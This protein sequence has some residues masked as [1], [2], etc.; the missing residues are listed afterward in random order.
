MRL[1]GKTVLVTGGARRIG[2]ALSLALAARGCHVVIHSRRPLAAARRLAAQVRRQRVRAWTVSGDFRDAGA[3]ARVFREAWTAAGRI[4]ILINNAAVFRKQPL[5][6]A[7]EDELREHWDVNLLAPLLL[8]RAFARRARHGLVLNL[9][10]TRVASARADAVPYALSK[11]SL[12]DLTRLAA[13]ELAPGFRVNGLAPGPV[14]APRA[15][16]STCEPAGPIPLRRRP[17]VRDVAAAAIFLLE[18]D[19][20]TGQVLFVDGGQHLLG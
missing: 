18:S 8:T 5:R 6:R 1:I 17:T 3:A 13:A 20:V 9:L 14:L 2:R 15:S 10:D 4:D 11:K 19:A 7:A 16:R 12:A